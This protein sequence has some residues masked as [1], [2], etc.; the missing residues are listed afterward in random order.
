MPHPSFELATTIRHELQAM[1]LLV[2][3]KSEL[4]SNDVF[5]A[6][7]QHHIDLQLKKL[8]EMRNQ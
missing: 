3:N 2:S 5:M 7:F 4:C 1:N 6:I 8:Q